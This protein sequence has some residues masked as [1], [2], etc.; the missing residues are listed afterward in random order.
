MIEVWAFP[1]K[2][3]IDQF[4]KFKKNQMNMKKSNANHA[5]KALFDNNFNQVL[6][7]N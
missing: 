3:S 6:K 7:N 5:K 4:M 2:D 1:E